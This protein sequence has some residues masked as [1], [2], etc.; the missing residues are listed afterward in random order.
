MLFFIS[1]ILT[2]FSNKA[3][4]SSPCLEAISKNIVPLSILLAGRYDTS[5]SAM[6]LGVT[7]SESDILVNFFIATLALS[8]GCREGSCIRELM[9][10]ILKSSLLSTNG[11]HLVCMSFNIPTLSPKLRDILLLSSFVVILS[12]TCSNDIIWELVKNA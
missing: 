11:L 4:A 8:I 12:M 7:T 5:S 2:Y 9:F 3:I 1:G 6:Y 10:C